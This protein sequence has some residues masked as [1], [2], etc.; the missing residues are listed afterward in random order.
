MGDATD[1]KSR[2]GFRR[3]DCFLCRNG[4]DLAGRVGEMKQYDLYRISKA[5]ASRI[6][7]TDDNLDLIVEVAEVFRK[8]LDD[9][10]EVA[11]VDTSDDGLIVWSKSGVKE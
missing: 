9:S 11:I 7:F 5:H 10:F 6:G 3:L 1:V 8:S 4:H 2:L